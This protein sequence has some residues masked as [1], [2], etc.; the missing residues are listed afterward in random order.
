MSMNPMSARPA[1]NSEVWIELAVAAC[2]HANIDHRT[3][4]SLVTWDQPYCANAVYRINGHQYLK[5]FG[6][7]NLIKSYHVTIS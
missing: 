4:E 2:N 1:A 5:I 7:L 3:I 6:L